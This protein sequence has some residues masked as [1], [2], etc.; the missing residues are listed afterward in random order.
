[1]AN[2]RNCLIIRYFLI[3]VV[4]IILIGLLF[5]DKLQYLSFI[6]PELLSYSILIFGFLVFFFKI[7]QYYKKKLFVSNKSNKIRNMP[8]KPTKSVS[9][10]KIH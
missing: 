1:M 8:R 6:T 3:S 4:F 9:S 10:K 2:C 5:T 7:I